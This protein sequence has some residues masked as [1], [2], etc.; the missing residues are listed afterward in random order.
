MNE[1]TERDVTP[2]ERVAETERALELAEQQ[3]G[4]AAVAHRE[5]TQN[6]IDALREFHRSVMADQEPRLPAREPRPIGWPQVTGT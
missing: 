5:A 6:Y 3:R 2:A 1:A 4:A